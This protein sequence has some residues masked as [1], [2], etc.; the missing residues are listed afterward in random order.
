MSRLHIFDMDGTLLSGSACLE[1][2]RHMG[3]LDAVVAIE[4]RW[5]HGQVGHVEFYELCLPLWEGLS[6]ADVDAVF[7][8]TGWLEGIRAVWADIAARGEH[9]AVISLSPQFFV[10][11][12]LEWGL[13]SAHGALVEAGIA[14]DPVKVLTPDS[15]PEVASALMERYELDSEDC[16]AYGDSSSDIPL[17]QM[18]TNTV[19][20]NASPS[21]RDI[22][23]ATYEGN[24]LWDAYRL[25]RSLLGQETVPRGS[26]KGKL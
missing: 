5:S 22:A 19:A 6:A 20:V 7:E 1:I 13:G 25:G 9:S 15:K 18:L 11:R 4:E 17:F 14:P 21:L 24:N 16:V 26:T 10:D 12:L 2:S 3:Q 23:A 8:A